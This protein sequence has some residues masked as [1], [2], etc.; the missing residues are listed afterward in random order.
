[1]DATISNFDILQVFT[2]LKQSIKDRTILVLTRPPK[3]VYSQ[4]KTKIGNPK[5]YTENNKDGV[6]NSACKKQ[7][8]AIPKEIIKE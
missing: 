7:S 5:D 1:M 2:F 8:L 4:V 3:V 6:F